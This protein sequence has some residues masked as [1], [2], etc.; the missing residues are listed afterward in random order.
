MPPFLYRC[1]NTGDNVQAWVA[2][3]PED[4]DLTYVS[5]D[6]PCVRP[7]AHLVN[8]KSGKVLGASDD[9]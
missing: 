8:P 7:K 4:D 1:P 2:D 6:V 3:A 5:G 9:E